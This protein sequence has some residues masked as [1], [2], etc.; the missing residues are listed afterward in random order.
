[1]PGEQQ[2]YVPRFLLKNFS[3]GKKPKIFVYDK[4]N[5]TRFQTNIKNVAAE[6]GFYELESGDD[7]LTMEPRLSQLEASTSGIIKKLIDAKDLKSL[8]EDRTIQI[9]NCWL[10][11]V[12]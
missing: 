6:N 3:H 10:D 4:S 12:G 1:M 9:F 8:G 7:V 5:D 11:I 2:H